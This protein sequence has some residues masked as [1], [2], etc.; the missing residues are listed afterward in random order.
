[1]IFSLTLSEPI[2]LGET[3]TYIDGNFTQNDQRIDVSTATV[4]GE[5]NGIVLLSG[6]L[7]VSVFETFNGSMEV[8]VMTGISVHGEFSAIQVTSLNTKDC[9]SYS[10]R[11][12]RTTTSV[13]VLLS[14]DGC[15]HGR[16]SSG[17]IAAI[18]IG[19]VL[20]IGV[21]SFAC[22]CVCVCVHALTSFP[23]DPHRSNRTPAK[24]W[25]LPSLSLVLPLR[26]KQ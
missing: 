4:G 17:V 14:N 11:A 6:P 24:A 15:T 26:G 25:D 18:S 12:I 23:A 5:A 9:A 19:A 2:S 7:R 8:P 10:A 22:L 1:M 21:R 16:L 13:S 20:G 3:R